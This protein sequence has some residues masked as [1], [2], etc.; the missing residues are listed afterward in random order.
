MIMWYHVVTGMSDRVEKACQHT[1]YTKPEQMLAKSW[2][3][4]DGAVIETDASSG[5]CFTPLVTIHCHP[6]SASSA[7][8]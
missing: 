2:G 6:A 5:T 4:D 7:R 3:T 1:P 8:R